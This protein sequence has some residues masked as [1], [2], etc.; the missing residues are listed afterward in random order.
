MSKTTRALALL[1]LLLPGFAGAQQVGPPASNGGN[2]SSA[3]VTATGGTTARTLAD[4]WSE[5]DTGGLRCGVINVKDYGAV[6]DGSTDSSAAFTAAAAAANQLA[7]DFWGRSYPVI[8]IPAGQYV[9]SGFDINPFVKVRGRGEGQTWLIL[10]AGSNRS[11]IRSLYLPQAYSA[12]TAQ[13]S[14]S[15]IEGLT[16]DGNSSGQTATSHCIEYTDDPYTANRVSPAGFVKHVQVFSCH[17]DGIYGGTGR[18]NAELEAVQTN[19][20]LGNGI[21][22]NGYDWFLDR[23]FAGK[24]SLNGLLVNA[25][26]CTNV[27]NSSFWSNTLDGVKLASTSGC[28]FWMTSGSLDRNGAAG[29]ENASG[30]AAATIT[31]VHFS[32]NSQTTDNTSPHIL[33]GNAARLTLTGVQFDNDGSHANTPN[34]LIQ[35]TGSLG[36]VYWYGSNWTT[37][38]VAFKTGA[39]SNPAQVKGALTSGGAGQVD[40]NTGCHA[41]GTNAFMLETSCS[42]NTQGATGSF[43]VAGGYNSTASN[44]ASIALGESTNA[45]G[46]A[47]F[48][49]GSGTVVGNSSSY[50][51][52]LGHKTVVNAYGGLAHAATG[53]T[54]N[55][56]DA[57]SNISMP[58]LG[59]LPSAGTV[60]MTADNSGSP[61][62][63]CNNS[64]PMQNNMAFVI[65]GTVMYHNT[66]GTDTA[67]YTINDGIVARGGGVSSMSSN[68]VTFTLTASLGTVTGVSAPTL[69]T[70]TTLGCPNISVTSTSG[71]WH[72]YGDFRVS[73]VQ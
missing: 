39:F 5:C 53:F 43:S 32:N 21:Q 48:T 45:G 54:A 66:A 11:V 9:V 6:G 1:C 59:N 36:P 62:S 18:D 8:E 38:P 46:Y 55:G 17:D 30:S 65:N 50:G 73:Q 23:T 71:T 4:R 67:V 57:Q 14:W 72:A 64:M 19:Y 49:A 31:G 22:I 68:N 41:I 37:S 3:T 61:S 25:R 26:G 20:T 34:Y 13:F 16:I 44:T 29:F 69:T 47:S 51:I 15:S 70:D 58:L 40:L 24:A 35:Q 56:G 12:G 2:A 28:Y 27:V 33:L 7:S 63:G 60:R 10:K 52:A 42:A